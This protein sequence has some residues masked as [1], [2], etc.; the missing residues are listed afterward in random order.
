[1]VGRS[2]IRIRRTAGWGLPMRLIRMIE[3]LAYRLS[4]FLQMRA[5]R[6]GEMDRNL[7]TRQGVYL[8]HC[9]TE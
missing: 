2:F 3:S 9:L 4:K 7:S 8:S 1:M 6:V 5:G